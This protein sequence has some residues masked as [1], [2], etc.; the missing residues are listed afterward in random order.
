MA[1]ADAAVIKFIEDQLKSFRVACSPL[2]SARINTLLDLIE[3][4]LKGMVA[5]ID[6]AY[7]FQKF[8]TLLNNVEY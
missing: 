4:A 6:F 8:P 2:N 3:G 5:D 1:A 7:Y